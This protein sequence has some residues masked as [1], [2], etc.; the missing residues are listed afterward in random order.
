MKKEIRMSYGEVK[1]KLLNGI[2]S[3]S[4]E[5][6]KELLR[7]M[8]VS[9]LV[10]LGSS[11]A[12]VKETSQAPFETRVSNLLTLLGM[13]TH[14]KGHSYTKAAIMYL[15]ERKQKDGVI[16]PMTKELYPRVAE[17]FGSTGS[18][19]ERAIRHA[20]EVTWSRG[21]IDVLKE[22]FGYTIDINKGK[23]TNSEFVSMLVEYLNVNGN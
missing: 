18:K 20:V 17:M 1:E 14:I 22:I 16:C 19:V 7:E 6:C 9:L 15:Y 21:D 8:T 4:A 11:D 10:K 3:M 23:P 12:Q 2:E 13:P 5:E